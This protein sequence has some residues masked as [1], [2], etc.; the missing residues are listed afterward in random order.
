MLCPLKTQKK[1]YHQK[2]FLASKYP[3][4]CVCGPR[5][6][7]DP[8][9]GGAHSAPQTPLAGL[10]EGT[11]RKRRGEERGR[12][13]GEGKEG[14]GREG[15]KPRLE[16]GIRRC[17]SMSALATPTQKCRASRSAAFRG[18]ACIYA[19][20]MTFRLTTR[21]QRLHRSHYITLHYVNRFE[22][23]NGLQNANGWNG[24]TAG[25]IGKQRSRVEE[26]KAVRILYIYIRCILVGLPC[27]IMNGNNSIR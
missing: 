23:L 1:H 12:K 9:A 5:C 2:H 10:G 22:A 14:E 7:P 19:V 25:T 16:S 3:P 11:G 26:R 8:A 18:R 24:V 20:I 27:T 15:R 6:S 4:K 13:R 21:H 17:A